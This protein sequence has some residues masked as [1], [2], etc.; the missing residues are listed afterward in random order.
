MSL[1]HCHTLNKIPQKFKQ[2]VCLVLE[3]KVWMLKLVTEREGQMID[4][5]C[6]CP[7][8]INH[9]WRKTAGGSEVLRKKGENVS[10]Y[11]ILE[12]WYFNHFNRWFIVSTFTSKCKAPS[13]QV[14]RKNKSIYEQIYNFEAVPQLTIGWKIKEVTDESFLNSVF[15]ISIYL[16]KSNGYEVYTQHTVKCAL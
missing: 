3:N 1:K 15:I 8:N 14:Q 11:H 7:I 2:S 12:M 16:F 9:S 13:W 10:V 4:T 5:F 6:V